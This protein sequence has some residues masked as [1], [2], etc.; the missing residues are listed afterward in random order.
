MKVHRFVFNSFGENTYLV[1][2]ES[3]KDA[4]VIDPGMSN[5]N[6][7]SQFADF[8]EKNGLNLRH[9]LNTHMHLDHSIGN[10]FI[11]DTYGVA[12]ECNVADKPLAESLPGQARMLGMSYTGVGVDI[13]GDLNDGDVLDVASEP[14]RVLHVPGHTM[15]HLA[16]YF[17]NSAVVFSGDALFRL[18]IGR[19]D[20]PGGD[21]ASLIQSIDKKL[22]SL[23]SDTLVLPGHGPNTT[24]GFE[25]EN[26][27]YL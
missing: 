10:C 26:N 27:P 23:P 8:V 3:S 14:C 20:L 11:E 13:K 5:D 1:W 25:I 15:G 2:D 4:A 16:F 22:F 21:Y 6:E 24:I 19:T 17:P 9:L 18:S 7:R 12:T